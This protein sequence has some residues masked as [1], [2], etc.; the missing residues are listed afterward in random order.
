MGRL[1]QWIQTA[2][3]TRGSLRRTA[4]AAPRR[5][6]AFERCESRIALSAADGDLSELVVDDQDQ[7]LA[8]EDGGTI[9]LSFTAADASVVVCPSTELD[10]GDGFLPIPV[11]ERAR[12]CVGS[13]S[14]ARIDPWS[15]VRDLELHARGLAGRRNV[16]APPGDRHGLAERLLRAGSAAGRQLPW[17]VSYKVFATKH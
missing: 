3:S 10:L 17:M 11:R 14:H 5:R 15:E 9:T 8:I 2:A 12:L 13:D 1:F 7:V 6:L 4:T 16:L